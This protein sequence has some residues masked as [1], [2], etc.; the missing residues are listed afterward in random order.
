M[1]TR[2]DRVFFLIMEEMKTALTEQKI[3]HMI[4]VSV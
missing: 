2:R 3:C 1:M 4:I